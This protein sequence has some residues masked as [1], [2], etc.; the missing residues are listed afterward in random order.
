MLYLRFMASVGGVLLVLMFAANAWLPRQVEPQSTRAEQGFDH[1]TIRI[2]AVRKGP[3]RV[4]FDTSLPTMPPPAAAIALNN[5]A[6]NNDMTQPVTPAPVREALAQL[7][8]EAASVKTVAKDPPPPHKTHRR[9]AQPR[10]DRQFAA[11]PTPQPARWQPPRL[12][13]GMFSTPWGGWR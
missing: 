10:Y 5:V 3:E 7:P 1:S 13:A 9:I 2:T 4:V 11:R 6:L 12:F 8:V